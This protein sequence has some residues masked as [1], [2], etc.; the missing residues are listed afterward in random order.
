MEGV[1]VC[2]CSCSVRHPAPAAAAGDREATLVQP[3]LQD[4]DAFIVPGTPGAARECWQSLDP[5]ANPRNTGRL[6]MYP[7]S[8]FLVR[9]SVC[10]LNNTRAPLGQALF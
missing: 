5:M 9:L 4:S 3:P 7:Q 8:H 1:H 6:Q 2:A 10:L